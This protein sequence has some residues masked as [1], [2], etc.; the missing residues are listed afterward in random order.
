MLVVKNLMTRLLARPLMPRVP[1]SLPQSKET[2]VRTLVLRRRVMDS[3]QS[4]AGGIALNMYH[5]E[6]PLESARRFVNNLAARQ[7]WPKYEAQSLPFPE[8]VHMFTTAGASNGEASRYATTL[9]NKRQMA[10]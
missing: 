1:N 6:V 9:E 8:L 2:Y 7:Y 3:L 4:Q 5:A 10:R